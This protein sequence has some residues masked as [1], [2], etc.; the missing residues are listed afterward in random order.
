MEIVT[1]RAVKHQ[2][3][4]YINTMSL[5]DHTRQNLYKHNWSFTELNDIGTELDIQILHISIGFSSLNC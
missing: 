2:W 4:N 1:S 5:D 3:S